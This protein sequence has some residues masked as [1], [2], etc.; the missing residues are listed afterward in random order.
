MG[1]QAATAAPTIWGLSP[2][3]IHDRF[4]ASRGVQVVRR[5]EE[6]ALSSAPELYLLIDPGNL[7]VFQLRD[8]VE[9]LSWLRPRL[10]V[11][12]IR[13]RNN[14]YRE[15]V[16]SDEHGRFVKFER[17]Y[18]GLASRLA[19]VGLTPYRDVALAWQRADSVADGWRALRRSIPS[20]D[21][22]A[23]SL[24]GHLFDAR[25]DHQVMASLECVMSTWVQ[26]DS[27]VLRVEQDDSGVWVDADA[28]ISP[29]AAIEGNVWVG[30]GRVVQERDVI[31]GPAVLWDDPD[32]SAGTES[33][34]WQQLEPVAVSAPPVIKRPAR[35]GK[36]AFDIV[37]SL[38]ALALTLPLYPVI[39][40]AI[41]IEDGWPIFFA[42]R[43]E[44]LRGREF[45]CLKFRSM[46]RDAERIKAELQQENRSDGPQFFVQ[47]DPR[48]TRVGRFLRKTQL[49]ELPQF[50][51]VLVGHMSVVGPRP[52]PRRE[53]QFCPPWR[54]ARL[55]VRPGV[56][57]LWQVRRTRAEGLDFQEWIRYDIEYVERIGWWTDL[58]IIGSTI[59]VVLG[60]AFGR[61]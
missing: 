48:S 3:Q 61:A 23:R 54:E 33:V 20:E 36:R 44:T 58:K 38:G 9:P 25:D 28:T 42:H 60:R 34:P 17:I 35:I 11:V 32:Q 7:V 13:D 8:L 46:R 39:A 24:P 57:G 37:F 30:A 47:D 27:T 12:R 40:A 59:R 5:G 56:T 15:V 52:S 31:V 4:W 1:A 45:P 49:D 10:M 41:F 50:L 14:R 29:Q 6:Q 21:R 43:R 18:D 51:N 16:R 26:P 53:N 19:R 2:S 55:S 22:V